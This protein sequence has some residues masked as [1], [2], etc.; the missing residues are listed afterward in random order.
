MQVN[1]EPYSI[2]N[3]TRLTD[4]VEIQQTEVNVATMFQ[5]DDLGDLMMT[6]EE[7]CNDY[8]YDSRA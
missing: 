1:F 6:M 3:H 5:F 8:S 2:L 4:C 7:L